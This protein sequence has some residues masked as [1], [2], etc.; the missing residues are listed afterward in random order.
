MFTVLGESARGP[1]FIEFGNI[2]GIKFNVE[3]T[4]NSTI[5]IITNFIEKAMD[6]M[7]NNK[8]N[9]VKKINEISLK[10]EGIHIIS[11]KSL[12]KY[13]F[14][15]NKE[16]FHVGFS[17]KKEKFPRIIEN[18]AVF[19]M[20]Y[21]ILMKKKNGKNQMKSSGISKEFQ[22]FKSLTTK[23]ND[24]TVEIL[25]KAEEILSKKKI[26]GLLHPTLSNDHLK[27][28]KMWVCDIFLLNNFEFSFKKLCEIFL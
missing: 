12:K 2:L 9:S 18:N 21:E 8:M 10:K 22:N 25:E 1:V 3:K 6:I 20:N 11:E 15:G 26:R 19:S 4:Y 14:Q 17:F 13:Q 24:E 27:D 23:N 5:Q 7:K 28:E 16:A